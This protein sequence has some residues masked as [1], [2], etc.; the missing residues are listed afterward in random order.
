MPRLF[1]FLGK[2][3]IVH[4][5]CGSCLQPSERNRQ[6]NKEICD[7]LSIPKYVIKKNPF[8]GARHGP[9]ERQRTC[10]NAHNMLRKARQK[11]CNTILQRFQTDA[12]YRDSLTT[13]GW[14]EN[15]ISAYDEI[16]K[17]DHSYNATRG[18]RSRNENSWGL[19]SKA[20]GANGP[21]DHRDD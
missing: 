9:T 1:I 11:K 21:L 2:I 4:C 20:E 6:L 3:G 5:P 12:L 14:D 17:E 13:I 19:V 7:V 10:H 15:I 8:H 16:E 18:E